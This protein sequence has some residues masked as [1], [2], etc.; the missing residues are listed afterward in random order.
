M[1]TDDPKFRGTVL[2]LIMVIIACTI[3][4]VIDYFVEQ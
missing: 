2:A 1:D 4:V 3:A